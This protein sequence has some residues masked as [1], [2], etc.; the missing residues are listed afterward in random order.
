MSNSNTAEVKVTD[1]KKKKESNVTIWCLVPCA[2]LAGGPCVSLSGQVFTSQKPLLYS[3]FS[4]VFVI[5]IHEE[6]NSGIHLGVIPLSLESWV[7]TDKCCSLCFPF[8]S[9]FLCESL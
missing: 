5:M 8:L 1:E 4:K 2:T 7:K 9:H 3:V 6:G